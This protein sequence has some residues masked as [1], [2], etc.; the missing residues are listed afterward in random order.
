[1]AGPE[2]FNAAEVARKEF[3]TGFRGFDQYEVRAYLARL[4][5]E[6]GVLQ[7]RERGLRERL[8]EIER[9]R[10]SDRVL[11]D[12]EIETALGV[13]ATKVIHAAREAGAE[14]RARAEENVARL[15]REAQDEAQAMRTEASA[16]LGAR[17]EEAEAAGNQI[18]EAAQQRG[19]EMVAEAQAVRERMLRDLARRRRHAETQIQLL[20]GGRERLVAAL[21]QAVGAATGTT[22]QLQAVELS[23]LPP[24]EAAAP[25]AIP[26]SSRQPRCSAAENRW[27]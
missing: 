16:L 2:D 10:P 4:A 18:V 27:P 21:E 3:A 25:E 15:L 26:P 24:M 13:E 11:A 7:E 12:E 22:E 14:I 6:M 9:K 8:I 17:T 19:R 5:A 23:D 20:L 1:M